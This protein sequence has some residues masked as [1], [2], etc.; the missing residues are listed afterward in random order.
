MNS[1]TFPLWVCIYTHISVCKQDGCSF[2]IFFHFFVLENPFGN[3]NFVESS[4]KPPDSQN[5]QKYNQVEEVLEKTDKVLEKMATEDLDPSEVSMNNTFLESCNK[6]KL[7]LIEY[8]GSKGGMA[9]AMKTILRIFLTNRK[10]TYL[11]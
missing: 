8:R 7:G 3:Q 6:D 2:Y 11:M 9:Y 10:T 5:I 4:Q 1:I